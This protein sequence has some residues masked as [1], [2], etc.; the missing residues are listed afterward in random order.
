M[1]FTLFSTTSRNMDRFTRPNLP[2]VRSFVRIHRRHMGKWDPKLANSFLQALGFI[3][4][5]V[6]IVWGAIR[7]RVCDKFLWNFANVSNSARHMEWRG[8][9]F[10][11]RW[12]GPL[13]L[14]SF[15]CFASYRLINQSS[16]RVSQPDSQW[17]SQSVSR[18]ISQSISQHS[19][20]SIPQN[21][22]LIGY[23]REN[24]LFLYVSGANNLLRPPPSPP[25]KK[26]Y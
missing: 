19:F 6:K 5:V 21:A 9:F 1:I 12:S 26:F 25:P 16:K 14:R 17:V 13:A 11:I 24:R 4:S 18:S 15:N 3:S 2:N 8:L 22:V 7:P 23:S 20:S 10:R